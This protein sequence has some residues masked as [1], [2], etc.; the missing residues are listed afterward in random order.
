MGQERR[1]ESHM[2]IKLQNAACGSLYS[3]MQYAWGRFLKAE[4]KTAI[5]ERE[6][7]EGI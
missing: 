6:V 5:G 2:E 4:Q 1:E 7:T 3:L